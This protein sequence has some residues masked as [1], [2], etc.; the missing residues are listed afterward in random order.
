[1]MVVS[2]Y[3]NGR[4]PCCPYRTVADPSIRLHCKSTTIWI[5][6]SDLHIWEDRQRIYSA[7]CTHADL[8]QAIEIQYTVIKVDDLT[9]D[10]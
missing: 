9:Q 5:E 8:K 2:S 4:R 10:I 7:Y 3:G 6:S 1:M